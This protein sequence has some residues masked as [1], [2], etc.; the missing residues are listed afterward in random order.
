MSEMGLNFLFFTADDEADDELEKPISSVIGLINLKIRKTI[1]IG[2][3]HKTLRT[4][5]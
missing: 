4:Y 2:W 5:S 1:F 3:Q